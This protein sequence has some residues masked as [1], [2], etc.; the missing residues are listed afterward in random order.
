MQFFA[1]Q[2]L[3]SKISR[4]RI[5]FALMSGIASDEIGLL[6]FFRRPIT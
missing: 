4:A 3:V 2:S 5:C 6:Y 1:V